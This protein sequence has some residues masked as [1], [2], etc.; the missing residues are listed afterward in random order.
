MLSMAAINSPSA[1]VD[2]FEED[3]YYLTDENELDD[4]VTEFDEELDGTAPSALLS[5]DGAADDGGVSASRAGRGGRSKPAPDANRSTPHPIAAPPGAVPPAPTRRSNQADPADTSAGEWYGR[6]AQAL[7]LQGRVQRSQFHAVLM[8]QLPDGSRIRAGHGGAKGHTPGWDLT[9]SAPKSVS[10]VAEITKDKRIFDAHRAAVH[11][12]L[13]W[14]EKEALVYR[15]RTL[16][17][18]RQV[19]SQSMVAA[20]FQHHSSRALDPDLHTHA[21]VANATQR[22]DGKWVA[23]H[24]HPL[25][26]HKMATG[27]VYRARLALNLQRAGYRIT[28]TGRGLFELVGVP[29]TL[30]NHFAKRRA[31][32]EKWM[33]EKKAHGAKAASR[34]ALATRKAK[35]EKPLAELR[36]EWLQDSLEHHFDPHTLSEKAREAG[37]IAPSSFFNAPD[38]TRDAVHAVA[39]REAVFPHFQVVKE[40][41]ERGLGV[42]DVAAVEAQLATLKAAKSLE[43]VIGEAGQEYLTPRAHSQELRVLRVMKAGQGA[44][45]AITTERAARKAL[46][47]LSTDDPRPLN[48][49]QVTTALF[50][51]TTQDRIVGVIGRPGAGKTTMLKRTREVGLSK[52]YLWIGMAPN[53][54]AARTLG[55]ET[56]M[57]VATVNKHMARVRSDLARMTKAGR[58]TQALIKKEYSKQVWV[59]DEASQLGNSMMSTLTFAA[60]RLGARLVL[61]GD[62]KGQLPAIQA[63]P[64]MRLMIDNGMRHARLDKIQRQKKHEIHKQAIKDLADDRVPEALKLLSSDIR[65]FGDDPDRRLHALISAYGKLSFEDAQKT[66]ILTTRNQDKIL[67]TRAVRSVLRNKE[68]LSGEKSVSQLKRV[69]GSPA[70]RR[71]ADLYEAPSRKVS[72]VDPENPEAPPE[73]IEQRPETLVYFSDDAPEIGVTKGEYLLVAS[74]NRDTNQVELRRD[75]TDGESIIWDPRTVPG[76]TRRV[77]L[78]HWDIKDPEKDA[79]V[80]PGE[81][82]RW[83]KNDAALGLNNGQPLKVITVTSD[84]LTV[85]TDDGRQVPL[86]LTQRNA[87]HW[88]HA[89]VS[90]VFSGQ[91]KTSKNALVNVDSEDRALLNRKSFLV[92]VSRHELDL[93][94]FADDKTKLQQVLVAQRGDKTSA[95]ES[96]QATRL[97]RALRLLESIGADWVQSAMRLQNSRTAGRQR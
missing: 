60:D 70:D 95:I 90:T 74:V 82:I 83:T 45:A 54:E 27:V 38:V 16:T 87:W 64:P 57:P 39:D 4:L 69:F 23:V 67:L 65:E 25:F 9:F 84:T 13:Q 5:D 43:T 72:I 36:G 94:V 1:T 32:M 96:R 93:T 97:T 77:E 80:A 22:D 46:T 73:V 31:Q 48:P 47:K 63:G 26:L 28:R 89:Y 55:L 92:A 71:M 62:P 8:G 18:R 12:A 20:L 30:L 86:D 40:A 29:E 79:T 19:N 17:G 49:D 85:Q 14:L 56:G 51:L 78:F 21:I 33:R 34:A 66:L 35:R 58:L 52:G 44:V 88:D 53:A 81:M 59:V 61:V 24:S 37:P 15:K 50:L 41:L 10:I 68:R 2:Y 42:V 3:D 11:E 6:G 76:R 91:G 75:A 7:G